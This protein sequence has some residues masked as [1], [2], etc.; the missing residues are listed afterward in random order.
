LTICDRVAGAVDG[1]D[2]D[3]VALVQSWPLFP[4]LG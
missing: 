3:L 2:P 1:R 4:S